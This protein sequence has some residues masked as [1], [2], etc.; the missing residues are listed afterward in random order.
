M[1]G[2]RQWQERKDGGA[3]RGWGSS[4][5]KIRVQESSWS[6][7]EKGEGYSKGA[8]HIQKESLPLPALWCLQPDTLSSVP[9]LSASSWCRTEQ[10]ETVSKW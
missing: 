1:G 8:G 6:S 10:D 3:Y 5:E 4:R 2:A 7:K 9:S